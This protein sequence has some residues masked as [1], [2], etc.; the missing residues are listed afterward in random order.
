M[1]KYKASEA[2][3]LR[4]FIAKLLFFH[5]LFAFLEV[6]LYD[7]QISLI[8]AE[9]FYMWVCY[10]CYMTLNKCTCFFYVFLMF[11]APVS[12]IIA[13]FK[14]GSGFLKPLIYLC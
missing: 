9:L 14:V 2:R 5:L 3:K 10:Y 8:G 13:L 12:G 6:F 1:K 11:V 4:D 7:I